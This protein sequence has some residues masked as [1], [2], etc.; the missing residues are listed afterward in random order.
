VSDDETLSLLEHLVE[1]ISLGNCLLTTTAAAYIRA[2]AMQ[3]QSK[4]DG[5]RLL[6]AM[7]VEGNVFADRAQ[8]I[9]Y[10]AEP[11]TVPLPGP[12]TVD[13]NLL[14]MQDAV[15]FRTYGAVWRE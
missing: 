5:V 11:E 4:K 3:V 15:G 6:N 8:I 14:L 9:R 2:D 12:S 13:C 1:T 7:Y 10:N